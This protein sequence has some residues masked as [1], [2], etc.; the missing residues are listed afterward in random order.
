M[1]RKTITKVEIFYEN[2]EMAII[3]KQYIEELHL[4]K[5]EQRVGYNGFNDI[6]DELTIAHRASLVV[7][8]DIKNVDKAGFLPYNYE[9]HTNE[10]RYKSLL[11]RTD[12]TSFVVHTEDYEGHKDYKE[13]FVAWDI[14]DENNNNYCTVVERPKVGSIL[15]FIS[16][17]D[18]KEYQDIV[19]AWL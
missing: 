15:F 18:P 5:I 13:Y 4:S 9:E 6:L 10:D 2:T 8:T 14:L 11:N 17:E 12:I 3:P 19:N 7:S 16:D 1:A